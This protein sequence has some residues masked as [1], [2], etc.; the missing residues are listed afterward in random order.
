M[1]ILQGI[2]NDNSVIIYSLSHFVPNLY[3]LISCVDT[4]DVNDD[5]LYGKNTPIYFF[6][7]L[8]DT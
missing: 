7:V 5:F 1:D 8:P 3:D 4:N 2:K 6:L